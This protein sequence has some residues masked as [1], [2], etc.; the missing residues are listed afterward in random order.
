[1]AFFGHSMGALL[2]F[3]VTRRFEPGPPARPRPL[4]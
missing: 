4:S 3:E 1:M 2:A